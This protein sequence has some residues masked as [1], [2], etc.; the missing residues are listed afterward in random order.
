MVVPR[1]GT[2]RGAMRPRGYTL[3]E[4]LVALALF[5]GLLAIALPPLGRWRDRA[6]VLAAREELASALAWTR[7]AAA[8]RGG[9]DL[10]LDPAAG[11]F[12]TRDPVTARPAVDLRARYGVR[13]D[14]GTSG[15]VVFHYDALGIARLSNRTVRIRRRGAET[16]LVVSA[17]GR[18][19]R[20]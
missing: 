11:R 13:V 8:S 16:A 6:A 12:W 3:V 15:V 7:M 2:H 9:A 19:R 18:V 17:Y 10:L 20:W 14:A 4:L 1:P 5:A